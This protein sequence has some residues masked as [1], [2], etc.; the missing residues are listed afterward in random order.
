MK[1]LQKIEFAAV[2]NRYVNNIGDILKLNWLPVEERRDFNLLKLTFKDVRANCFCASSCARK[3]T[4]HA[5]ACALSMIGQ[6]AI[7]IAFPGFNDLG[8]TVT[9][10]FLLM[11]HF[12]YQFSALNE[13][14]KK[15]YRLEV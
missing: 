14:M 6:M 5:C 15:I 4:R 13:K 8:R 1:H 11:D 12:L 3:L 7:A 2:Y 10:A 9:P